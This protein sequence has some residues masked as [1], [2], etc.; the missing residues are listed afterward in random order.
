MLVAQKESP[1]K[2]AILAAWSDKVHMAA[3]RGVFH[4]GITREGGA[5][6]L[7]IDKMVELAEE[8]ID[9][10]RR[11]GYDEGYNDGYDEGYESAK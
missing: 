6:M 8:A 10:A 9:K 11:D 2:T 4:T 3:Q 7:L 1:L 5:T